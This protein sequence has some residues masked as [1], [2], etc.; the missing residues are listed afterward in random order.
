MFGKLKPKDLTKYYDVWIST[1][2]LLLL[3]NDDV[4]IPSTRPLHGTDYTTCRNKP[5]LGSREVNLEYD[6]KFKSTAPRMEWTGV[7]SL[8]EVG[9][10]TVILDKFHRPNISNNALGNSFVC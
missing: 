4:A 7:R 9:R 8:E 5:Y 2:V 3:D 10:L 6:A 1:A